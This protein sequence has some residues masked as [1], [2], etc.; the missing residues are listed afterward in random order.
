MAVTVVINCSKTMLL[1]TV[2]V[3]SKSL[4]LHQLSFTAKLID[5]GQYNMGLMLYV[6]KFFNS[7]VNIPLA[8]H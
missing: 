5:C 7:S 4:H 1:S 8:N 6:Y 2:T 3:N